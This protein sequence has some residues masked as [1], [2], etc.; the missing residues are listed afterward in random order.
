M[1]H[2]IILISLFSLVACKKSSIEQ[3]GSPL[4]EESSS[5]AVLKYT[6]CPAVNTPANYTLSGYAPG[7]L[8]PTYT[9]AS[10]KLL[11]VI[12]TATFDNSKKL[13]FQIP[14]ATSSVYVRMVGKGSSGTIFAMSGCTLIGAGGGSVTSATNV[15]LGTI[16]VYLEFYSNASTQVAWVRLPQ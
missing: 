8:S 9:M 16:E 12:H 4:K 14:L 5:N 7:V 13:S 3:D 1:K 10:N 15:P 11:R 2:V 6:G